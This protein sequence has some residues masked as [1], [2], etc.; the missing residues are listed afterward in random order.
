MT[1]LIGHAAPDFDAATLTAKGEIGKLR[2]SE[3]RGKWVALIFYPLDFTF[4]CPTELRAVAERLTA[5]EARKTLPLGVSTD[6]VYSHKAWVEG[7]LGKVGFPLVSDMKREISRAY[8]VLHEE[9]GIALRGTVLIDPAGIV[10]SLAVNDFDVGRSIDELLRTIDAFQT[11]EL[12]PAGWA[13]GAKTLG[14]G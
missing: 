5:F 10:R 1:Q 2:L 3:Q 4:V 13:R 9:E 12:C 14:K 8:G 6:S 7:S 11:G